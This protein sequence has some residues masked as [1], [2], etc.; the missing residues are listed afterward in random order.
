MDSSSRRPTD[1]NED[2]DPIAIKLA[3]VLTELLRGAPRAT[4]PTI[5][6]DDSPRPLKHWAKVFEVSLYTLNAAAKDGRLSATF[7]E[8]KARGRVAT[9]AAV[10]A[11]LTAKPAAK[12]AAPS[13]PADDY[14]A[15]VR[16]AR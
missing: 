10:V 3:V 14:L 4:G 11:F 8:G 16:G 6:P 9:R 2:L 15:S 13:A 5:E 1:T 12:T 7:P